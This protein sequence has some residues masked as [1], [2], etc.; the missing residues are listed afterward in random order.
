MYPS[1]HRITYASYYP[2][3]RAWR[4]L[5]YDV[6]GT[7]MPQGYGYLPSKMRSVM[8]SFC[9][10]VGKDMRTVNAIPAVF[11]ASL[12]LTGCVEMVAGTLSDM[13]DAAET[14]EN[15]GRAPANYRGKSCLE[16]AIDRKNAGILIQHTG[17]HADYVQKQGRWEMASVEQVEREQGCMAGTTVEQAG[18][19]DYVTKHPEAAKELQSKLPLGAKIPGNSQLAAAAPTESPVSK[20]SPSPTPVMAPISPSGPGWGSISLVS[21]LPQ[22]SLT[23]LIAKETPEKY[24]GKSCD[25]LRQAY[26]G[27]EQLIADSMPEAKA[28]GGSKKVA[29]SQVLD[30]RDCPPLVTTGRGRIGVSVGEMDPIKASRLKMPLR[31]VSVE[32]VIPGGNAEKA[33]IAFAD[34]IVSVDAAPVGDDV[35]FLLAMSKVP[36]GTSAQFKVWRQG[37]FIDV[38]VLVGP[39]I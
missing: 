2:T 38:S 35:E 27:S 17:E 4:V 16:L 24:Q 29:I 10:E 32:R 25:Y 18:A 39:P 37:T 15:V 6:V 19:I 3:A 13:S 12:C 28:L 11:L 26:A 1:Y 36:I 14:P 34:V 30:H 7:G 5:A 31:G 8:M 33:G 22:T 20:A 21:G 23:Q 9:H